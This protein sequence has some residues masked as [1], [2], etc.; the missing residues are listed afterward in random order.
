MPAPSPE[1]IEALE[2][3]QQ[4]ALDLSRQWEDEEVTLEN[5]PAYLPS[6]DEFAVEIRECK[7]VSL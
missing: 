7:A 4:A 6:F 5:Y 2:K 3:F 1:F